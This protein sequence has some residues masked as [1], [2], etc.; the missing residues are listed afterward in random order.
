M[1]D[2]TTAIFVLKELLAFGKAL[3]PGADG[4]VNRF[5]DEFGADHPELVKSGDEAAPGPPER[6]AIDAAVDRMISNG[7]V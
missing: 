7:D 5:V 1:M 2:P 6:P 3:S 4:L